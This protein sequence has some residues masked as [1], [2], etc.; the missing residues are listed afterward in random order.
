M[1]IYHP[2]LDPYHSAFRI[3]QILSFDPEKD[4][5]W[6]TL[7]ILDFYAVFPQLIT[8][9]VLPKQ[10]VTWRKVFSSFENPY[11]FSGDPSLVFNRMEPL[12]KTALD[13]LYAQGLADANKYSEQRVQVVL[14]ELKKLKLPI[15]ES[16]QTL[17]FLVTV[18]GSMP[19]H[20][21]GG[22]KDRTRLL[23]YRYDAA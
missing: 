9:I 16:S 10:H 13:L 4:Y 1:P 15:P 22:L 19:F 23:E 11:W 18:L 5:D 6:R 21:I 3:L 7:R 12:Q 20:G 14:S 17:K 2:A 8:K